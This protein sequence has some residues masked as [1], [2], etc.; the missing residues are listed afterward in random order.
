[1]GVIDPQNPTRQKENNSHY[2]DVDEDIRKELKVKYI[3]GKGPAL[4]K[5]YAKPDL[6]KRFEDIVLELSNMDVFNIVGIPPTKTYLM[7]GPPRTGKTYGVKVL[8]EELKKNTGGLGGKIAFLQYKI[9]QSGSKYI[10][11]NTKKLEQLFEYGQELLSD[12]VRGISHVVYFFDECDIVLKQRGGLHSHKEDDKMAVTIMDN[13]QRVT[14]SDTNEIIFMAS[15]FEEALDKAAT[16]SGRTDEI[17]RFELPDSQGRCLFIEGYVSELRNNAKYDMF[18]GARIPDLVEMS[19]GFNISDMQV[20]I[21]KSVKEIL[22]DKLR[23]VK[24]N[25]LV[26]DLKVEVSMEALYAQF[27]AIK[28]KK[29]NTCSRVVGF[30]ARN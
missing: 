10:N 20:G 1:M 14:E 30:N 15:N 12:P 24:T 19:K 23:K 21:Q 18:P 9:G 5:Y 4:D 29:G 22:K 13:Q 2:A 16:S 25:A 6:K 26:T 8:A 28:A 17:I 7:I 11:M 27:N 3:T